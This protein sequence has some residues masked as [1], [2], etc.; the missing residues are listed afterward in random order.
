LTEAAESLSQHEQAPGT[1]LEGVI[2]NLKEEI[3]AFDGKV[4]FEAVLNG[5]PR[6]VVMRFAK[7]DDQTRGTLIRAFEKRERIM[8]T[9]DLVRE[10]KRF[11]LESP[12]DLHIEAETDLD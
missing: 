4:T 8:V 11:R 9:G 10:G 7:L 3:A 1:E 12:H 2:T 5:A 6:R